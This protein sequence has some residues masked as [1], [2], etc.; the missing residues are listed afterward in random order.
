MAK[1]EN[2]S[3]NLE[4]KINYG[5]SQRKLTT[6]I[7]RSGLKLANISGPTNERI[8]AGISEE[9]SS[10]DVQLANIG[11][12][13]AYGARLPRV[14]ERLLLVGTD[15]R[16]LND[17]A[18]TDLVGKESL[19]KNFVGIATALAKPE[20]PSLAIRVIHGASTDI[21]YRGVSYPV[22]SFVLAEQL[23]GEGVDVQL[24]I[25]YA[26]H[27][28]GNLNDRNL[29]EVK[30]QSKFLARAQKSFAEKFFPEIAD[31]LI[32]LED[33]DFSNMPGSNS[34][35]RRLAQIMGDVLPD[36][37]Q[38]QLKMKDKKHG[39]NGNHLD[40]SGAHLLVHNRASMELFQPMFEDQSVAKEPAIILNYGGGSEGDFYHARTIASSF[41]GKDY[42]MPELQYFSR[43]RFPGYFLGEGGDIALST[44]LA[45]GEVPVFDRK[46]PN[47]SRGAGA[48]INYLIKV[49][50]ERTG[51][52]DSLGDFIGAFR[53]E[54]YE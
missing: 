24:Q 51:S 11:E 12:A 36:Q 40:Y 34:E 17:S 41:A 26:N 39:G 53:R 33:K 5:I 3:I 2:M 8:A 14:V 44:V 21:P 16:Q 6:A 23:L 52:I 18:Y 19:E 7:G 54:V 46:N 28:S 45:S 20:I 10:Q 9:L 31:S 29:D 35:M 48:D 32:F 15:G 25:I 37:L 38:Q 30:G 49:A 27:I 1:K 4:A 47:F 42:Q 22:P 50:K 43:H 13:V